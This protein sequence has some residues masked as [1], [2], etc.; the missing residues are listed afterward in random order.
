VSR[1]LP[2]SPKTYGKEKEDKLRQSLRNLANAGTIAANI[3]TSTAVTRKQV[4]Y[5]L[6][7][8]AMTMS[9]LFDGYPAAGRNEIMNESI[10]G[11]F[12]GEFISWGDLCS[13]MQ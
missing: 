13:R 1:N 6:E 12:Q 7:H 4:K 2:C 10:D 11:A 5:G 3:P 9:E 8:A